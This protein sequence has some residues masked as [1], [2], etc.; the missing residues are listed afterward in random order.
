MSPTLL[1][2]V[3]EEL[4]LEEKKAKGFHNPNHVRASRFTNYKTIRDFPYDELDSKEA[5]N[6]IFPIIQ[7]L[8]PPTDKLQLVCIQFMRGRGKCSESYCTQ[9]HPE[10]RN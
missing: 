9:I 3:R 10:D 5:N 1:A 8:Y 7:R 4:T 2:R 6:Y